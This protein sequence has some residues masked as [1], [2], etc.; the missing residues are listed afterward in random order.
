MGQSSLEWALDKIKETDLKDFEYVELSLRK[1]AG[2]AS[3]CWRKTL[4]ILTG[5]LTLHEH[6]A[7][8]A[9]HERTCVY[10]LTCYI[11]AH[12]EAQETAE[13]F[14]DTEGLAAQEKELVIGESKA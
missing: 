1:P 3:R 9:V 7:I 6:Y 5:A 2:I 12:R 8:V 4:S 13:K 14:L 10:V 11:Q